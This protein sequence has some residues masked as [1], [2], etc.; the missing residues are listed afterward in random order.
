[1]LLQQGVV[2]RVFIM[3]ATAT[4]NL[5]LGKALMWEAVKRQE[6]FRRFR[7]KVGSWAFAY[8]TKSTT[9]HDCNKLI[10]HDDIPAD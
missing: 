7:D 8:G 3:E 10:H 9:E 2:D 5:G 6:R 4:H 1:V